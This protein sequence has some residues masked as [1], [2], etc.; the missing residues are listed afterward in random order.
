MKE[1]GREK[2]PEHFW[3]RFDRFN[4]FLFFGVILAPSVAAL[5]CLVSQGN[6]DLLPVIAF[7]GVPLAG[8]ICGLH[9]SLTLPNLSPEGRFVTG[10]VSVIACT[11]ASLLPA[12]LGCLL[13]YM[14]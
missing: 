12:Y 13:I 14:R 10:V 2:E 11:A 3:P 5:L 9:F 1:D 4:P 8:L 7:A 6:G